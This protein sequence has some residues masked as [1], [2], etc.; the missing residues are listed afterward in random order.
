MTR[1]QVR[2]II[3]RLKI[4]VVKSDAYGITLER[5]VPSIFHGVGGQHATYASPERWRLYSGS[6]IAGHSSQFWLRCLSADLIGTTLG[7]FQNQRQLETQ[8]RAFR[9]EGRR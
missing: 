5:L 6:G 2:K 7:P 4:K 1:E 8:L 3:D 9:R